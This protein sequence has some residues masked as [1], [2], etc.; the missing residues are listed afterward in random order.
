MCIIRHPNRMPHMPH[1]DKRARLEY[2]REY[3]RKSRLKNLSEG[4]CHCGEMLADWKTLCNRH[5]ENLRNRGAAKSQ[6]Y[7]KARRD[8]LH[9]ARLNAGLCRCGSE[10]LHRHGKR[11]KFCLKCLEIRRVNCKNLRS[12]RVSAGMC[13][14]C[15]SDDIPT[16]KT[17]C[18]SCLKKSTNHYHGRRDAVL[19]AYGNRCACCGE[20]QAEFLTVD[21]V[22]NDGSKHR[23]NYR[24]WSKAKSRRESGAS[25]YNDIIKLGFPPDFQILCWNC[26]LAKAKHG[27]CPHQRM[28]C[29]T[30][31]VA[32]GTG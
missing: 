17:L 30:P 31:T 26:N 27:Q 3:K 15:S 16:G 7:E 10:P 20:S 32:E 28:R 19:N 2:Q 12:R 18:S 24:P 6:K 23:Q 14:N 1:A 4:K 13:P 29:E 25:V 8:N 9:R 21:H 5:L 22:N 11:Y